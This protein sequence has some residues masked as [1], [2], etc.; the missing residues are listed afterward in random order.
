MELLN[1]SLSIWPHSLFLLILILNFETN[2]PDRK[3]FSKTVHQCQWCLIKLP[4]Y[5]LEDGTITR[6]EYTNFISS[7]APD[8]LQFAHGL[9][10]IYDANGDHH[11]GLTD[12]NAL[13]SKIDVDGKLLLLHIFIQ[14][15]DLKFSFVYNLILLAS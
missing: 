10:D 11:L 4:R 12:L 7:Q 14:D 15:F 1:F 9:Y 6:H 3:K 2:L 5:V 8:L 13:H